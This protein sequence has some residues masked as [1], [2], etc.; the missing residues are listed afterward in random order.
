MEPAQ[1][2]VNVKQQDGVRICIVTLC[3][4]IFIY[5]IYYLISLDIRFIANN[6]D[7][8]SCGIKSKYFKKEF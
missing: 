7:Y 2:P 3:Q 4:Y 6:A 5:N 8:H 1:S